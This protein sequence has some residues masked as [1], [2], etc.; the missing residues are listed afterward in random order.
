[1]CTASANSSTLRPSGFASLDSLAIYLALGAGAGLLAGLFGVGGGLIIVPVLAWAFTVQGMDAGVI[2]HLA[3]GTSLASIWL[4]SIM[5]IRAHHRR[6]AVA[7]PLVKQLAGGLLLGAFAGSLIADQLPTTALKRLF[8]GFELLVAAQ[9]LLVSRYPPRFDLPGR[10]GMAAAGGL[11]GGVSAIIG[12]GGGTLSVPFLAACRV[13]MPQAV[14]T[15]A[16]CGLPIAV[17]GALGFMLTGWNAANLPAWSSGYLYWPA[18]LGIVVASGLTAGLGARLAHSLPAER[19][20]QG[21]AG[22]LAI[23]G[24]LMLAA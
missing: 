15:A 1:M 21:F 5:S 12:I 17:T 4:T 18:W 14:A 9:M 23:I 16:A 19:L 10:A 24:L 6:G 11:I 20:R 7:W 13:P 3:V 8:G 2:M 22:L